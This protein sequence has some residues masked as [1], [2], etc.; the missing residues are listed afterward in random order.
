L[1][2]PLAENCFK[3]GIGKE[4]GKILINI[5]FN[6]KQLLFTTEN[7]IAL[8]EKTGKEENGGIGISNVEKR[9]NLL[10]PDRHTLQFEA[11]DGIYK[12]ELRVD[13]LK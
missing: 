11:K 12:V 1:L 9:L 3:H 13:L 10:Y 5:E 8:R 2:L 4:P 6:G 7:T